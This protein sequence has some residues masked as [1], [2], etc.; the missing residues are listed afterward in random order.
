MF[1][2]VPCGVTPGA[3]P[4]LL[5]FCVPRCSGTF[6]A[7]AEAA[8][9]P[10]PELPEPGV[11]SQLKALSPSS[12]AFPS[13]CGLGAGMGLGKA[14]VASPPAPAVRDS[15]RR[16]VA[17]CRSSA[18]NTTVGSSEAKA[19]SHRSWSLGA[20]LLLPFAGWLCCV[21]MVSVNGVLWDCWVT[22]CG[23]PAGRVALSLLSA[24]GLE[25][26]GLFDG[27]GGVGVGVCGAFVLV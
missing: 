6:G 22:R 26:P 9:V 21:F 8:D 19:A 1:C 5:G 15:A 4:W 20:E 24:F 23:W 3:V 12:E 11:L 14:R 13:S 2:G 10:L 17:C 25:G 7:E 16:E 27:F 18:V